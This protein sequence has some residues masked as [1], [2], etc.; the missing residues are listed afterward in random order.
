MFAFSLS[1]ILEDIYKLTIK[2]GF[3]G[4]PHLTA[5]DHGMV[6]GIYERGDFVLLHT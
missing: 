6:C 4:E 5:S 1:A 2:C 3:C